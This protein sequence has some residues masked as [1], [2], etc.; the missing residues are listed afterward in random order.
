M[1]SG[2]K[3]AILHIECALNVQYYTQ[4]GGEKVGIRGEK[5]LGTGREGRK[6]KTKERKRGYPIVSLSNKNLG[7]G[8]QTRL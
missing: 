7:Y 1:L 8:Q 4:E 6:G 3:D 5:G 2:V